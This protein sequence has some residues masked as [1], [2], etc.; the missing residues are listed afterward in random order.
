[1]TSQFPPELIQTLRK[2]ERV[3]VLTGAGISTESG[4]PAFHDP[5]DGLWSRFRPQDL[6]NAAAFRKDPKLVWGWYAWRRR[7]AMAVEPNAGHIALARMEA[8]VPKF[9]LIT[10]NIDGLHA[11]AGS[12]K[13]LELHGNLLRSKCLEENIVMEPAEGDEESPPRCSRCGAPLRPDVVWFGEGLPDPALDAA[14][15]ATTASEVFFAVGTSGAVNPAAELPLLAVQAGAMVVEISPEPTGMSAQVHVSLRG[16]A[17][18]M[19]SRLVMV[20]WPGGV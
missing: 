13:L 10:Q 18:A 16:Q 17:A 3:T 1:M 8:L 9:V 2:A 11:R 15:E 4:P 6:A 7:A 5:Q 19:L 20:T 12:R 14:L